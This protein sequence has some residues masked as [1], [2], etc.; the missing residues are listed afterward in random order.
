MHAVPRADGRILAY[1]D[2]HGEWRPLLR[3]CERETPGAVLLLG[4]CDLTVRPLRHELEALWRMGI[5][6][7]YVVGNHE[8]DSQACWENLVGDHPEGN[9]GN[10]VTRIAGL[11]VAGLGGTFEAPLWAPKKGVE[12]RFRTKE[13]MLASLL[14]HPFE[15]TLSLKVRASVAPADLDILLD[16][17]PADVLVCHEAPG[18]HRDGEPIIDTLAEAL[19]VKLIIHG[20][21]H[22][23][24]AA[25]LPCGIAVRGLGRAE[26][27]WVEP[28]QARAEPGG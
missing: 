23:S 28:V 6:V 10:R 16:Q 25:Q 20:H 27:W 5:P 1:G 4:D 7:W 9:L 11:R 13:D 8:A 3:A 12:S 17:E 26:P 14:G 18:S 22:E 15:G 19:G 21:H 2:P 24:Y